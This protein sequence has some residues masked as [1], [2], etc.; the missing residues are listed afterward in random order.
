VIPGGTIQ[1]QD[2]GPASTA[3]N[4]AAIEQ[5]VAG[6]P[7]VLPRDT[8]V[9]SGITLYDPGA[10]CNDFSPAGRWEFDTW[11]SYFAGWGIYA[12]NGR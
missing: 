2:V 3:A 1:A 5:G 8:G 9:G 4:A 12:A 10:V 6:K 7:G 11:T